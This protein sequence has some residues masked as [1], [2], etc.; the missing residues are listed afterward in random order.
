[1]SIAF[2]AVVENGQTGPS[3]PEIEARDLMRLHCPRD[4][5][6]DECTEPRLAAAPGVVHER[7]EAGIGRNA[8]CASIPFQRPPPG[9]TSV[10]SSLS[11][12][13]PTYQCCVGRNGGVLWAAPQ[14]RT[15]PQGGGPVDRRGVVGRG[16]WAG[17]DVTLA[18]AAA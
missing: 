8:M 13:S 3:A 16:E 12:L 6:G 17:E 14:H 2:G 9:A 11:S 4:Q 5:A 7:E 15:R 18:P 10:S 1:M